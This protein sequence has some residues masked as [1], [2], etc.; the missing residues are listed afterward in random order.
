MGARTRTDKDIFYNTKEGLPRADRE[1]AAAATSR[2]NGCVFCASVHARFA[3]HFS[4]RED[5]VD[6]LLENR[7]GVGVATEL[8]QSPAQVVQ[9]RREAPAVV[10]RAEGVRGASPD[11]PRAGA[12]LRLIRD[13]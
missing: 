7:H 13:E 2:E 8:P 1:L 12:R 4:G 10:E 3:A 9:D 5:D 6:R 11:D